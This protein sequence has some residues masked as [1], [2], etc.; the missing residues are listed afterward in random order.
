MRAKLACRMVV[1]A[2]GHDGSKAGVNPPYTSCA[3]DS[4]AVYTFR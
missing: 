4:G 1:G 3:M 2:R